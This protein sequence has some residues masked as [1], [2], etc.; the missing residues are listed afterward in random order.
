MILFIKK[1]KYRIKNPENPEMS[2]AKNLKENFTCYT[3]KKYRKYGGSWKFK[4]KSAGQNLREK[5]IFEK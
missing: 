5:L 3:L 1:L 4:D 2:G